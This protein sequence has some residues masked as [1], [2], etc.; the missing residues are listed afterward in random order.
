[1]QNCNIISIICKFNYISQCFTTVH[2]FWRHSIF[3]NQFFDNFLIQLF[4]FLKQQHQQTV[5]FLSYI[6]TSDKATNTK[7]RKDKYEIKVMK[8]K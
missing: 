2:T 7:E 3:E 4:L 1:M 6:K 8:Q 5:T